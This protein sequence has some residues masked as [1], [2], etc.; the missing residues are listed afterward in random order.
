MYGH[1]A[2][3]LVQLNGAL[4]DQIADLVRKG[5]FSPKGDN[6]TYV[7]KTVAEVAPRVLQFAAQTSAARRGNNQ[8]RLGVSAGPPQRVIW[9]EVYVQPPGIR[10][11]GSE[12]Q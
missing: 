8:V 9:L 11:E 2:T 5:D 10:T 1:N 6:G 3:P 12:E 4:C 7:V